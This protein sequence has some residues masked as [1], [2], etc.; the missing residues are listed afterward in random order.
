MKAYKILGTTDDVTTCELCG[1]DELKG[2]VT[3]CPLDVDG[4]EDG[5]AVYFG[6]SCAAKA[7]GW[8]QREV[9]AGVKAA[10]TAKREAERAERDAAWSARREWLAA[11]YLEHYGTSDLHEAAKL[12]GMST[13][14]L[15]GEAISAY[16]EMERATEA[17]AVVQEQPAEELKP[18]AVDAS[19]ESRS[20]T[21]RVGDV[22]RVI[23]TVMAGRVNTTKR[24][25]TSHTAAVKAALVEM[26]RANLDTYERAATAAEAVAARVGCG[27]MNK[28]EAKRA[29]GIVRRAERGTLHS[30]TSPWASNLKPLPK[31]RFTDEIPAYLVEV[32]SGHYA[33]AEAAE[34]LALI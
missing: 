13:V 25:E 17:A 22:E 11:W 9:R 21:L 23:R 1:R 34:Q 30:H 10:D 28:E 14:R 6:V 24:L 33:T 2:T 16:C 31:V 15:S 32:E 29:R 26:R 27:W 18:V 19:T 4:N 20:T 3:L 12:A 7:A 5:D 8:T